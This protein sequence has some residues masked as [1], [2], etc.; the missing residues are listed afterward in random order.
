MQAEIEE[1]ALDLSDVVADVEKQIQDLEAE[2]TNARAA[3]PKAA[4]AARTLA[5]PALRAQSL[6]KAN[7][8]R[9]TVQRNRAEIDDLKPML[10]VARVELENKVG[11]ARKRHVRTFLRSTQ[12]LLQ[13]RQVFSWSASVK[14]A[15]F[16]DEMRHII[17]L[18][19][20]AH[21]RF[22][23]LMSVDQAQSCAPDET[24]LAQCI[25]GELIRGGAITENALLSLSG[26]GLMMLRSMESPPVAVAQQ[27]LLMSSRFPDSDFEPEPPQTSEPDAPASK[28]EQRPAKRAGK[29]APALVD[30][31]K[32]AA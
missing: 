26:N 14:L 31:N 27:D 22:A 29:A 3:Y 18:G 20:L 4:L 13:Q 30:V 2:I 25:L 32:K 1:Q 5:T 24:W 23:G 19:R 9:D 12:E 11:E 21:R 6:A 10:A 15:G 7:A 8:L 16:V 28:A 17:N